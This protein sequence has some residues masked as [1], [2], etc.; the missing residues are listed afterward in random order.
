[1]RLELKKEGDILVS[2]IVVLLPSPNHHSQGGYVCI[3]SVSWNTR[4]REGSVRGVVEG[5]IR[6]CDESA[7]HGSTSIVDV[8]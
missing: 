4:I 1:M 7:C 8:V 2:E 3:M 5:R 6:W